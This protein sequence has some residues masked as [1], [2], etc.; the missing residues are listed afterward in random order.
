MPKSYHKSK[1]KCV[2]VYV[3]V[4][5]WLK[6]TWICQCPSRGNNCRDNDGYPHHTRIHWKRPSWCD[7]T[8]CKVTQ[9]THTPTHTHTYT[10]THVMHVLQ[11]IL[12]YLE[13]SVSTDTCTNNA[14][15]TY[16]AIPPC[17]S[18]VM[19]RPEKYFAGACNT[20]NC[21]NFSYNLSRQVGDHSKGQQ[22]HLCLGETAE[23]VAAGKLK[24]AWLL[25]PFPFWSFIT[26]KLL[27]RYLLLYI[28]LIGL[29][30]HFIHHFMCSLCDGGVFIDSQF[31]IWK[32]NLHVFL[33]VCVHSNSNSTMVGHP[34]ASISK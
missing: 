15:P 28:S 33:V 20:Q 27:C 23:E 9:R 5:V 8:I 21:C 16:H 18:V 12:I 10:Q 11:N 24:L 3:H 34:L 32:G 13:F 6:V 17:V 2:S 29:I 1:Y 7:R 31:F 14:R 25:C 22:S 19:N 26:F 4:C 30:L